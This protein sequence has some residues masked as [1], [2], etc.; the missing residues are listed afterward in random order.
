MVASMGR[1]I[2]I[3]W[4]D[5]MPDER[6]RANVRAMIDKQWGSLADRTI[7]RLRALC[8]KC[9]TTWWVYEVLPLGEQTGRV[10]VL[11][12]E[13]QGPC[14]FCDLPKYITDLQTPAIREVISA[15]AETPLVHELAVAADLAQQDGRTTHEQTRHPGDAAL[16]EALLR[17]ATLD[18]TFRDDTIAVESLRIPRSELKRLFELAETFDANT[19]SRLSGIQRIAKERERD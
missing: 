6:E 5:D 14:P 18:F 7:E 16:I 13:E 15:I 8:E 17:G 10:M 4:P 1:T 2:R 3:L 11:S 12:T 19:R 9:D